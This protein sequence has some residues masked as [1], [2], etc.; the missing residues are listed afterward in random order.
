MFKVGDL[1][2]RTTAHP[3]HGDLYAEGRTFRVERV[4]TR[5]VY[6]PDNSV[7]NMSNIELV[8]EAVPEAVPEESRL[9]RIVLVVETDEGALMYDASESVILNADPKVTSVAYAAGTLTAAMIRQGAT[10]TELG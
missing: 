5:N 3:G 6:G 8:Q 9:M 7:H 4:F 1:V 2:R 10:M